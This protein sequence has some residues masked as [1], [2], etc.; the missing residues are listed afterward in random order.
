ML[1]ILTIN[2]AIAELARM[3]PRGDNGFKTGIAIDMS[4]FVAQSTKEILSSCI[5]EREWSPR[6]GVKIS[7]SK[8][9]VPIY[10]GLTSEGLAHFQFADDVIL[11]ITELLVV[12]KLDIVLTDLWLAGDLSYVNLTIKFWPDITIKL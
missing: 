5:L 4:G 1:S 12:R 7:S 10:K 9:I 6:E 8:P 2:N 11:N 3:D